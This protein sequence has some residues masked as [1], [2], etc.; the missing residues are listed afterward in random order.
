MQ[1]L[2]SVGAVDAAETASLASAARILGRFLSGSLR[3]VFTGMPPAKRLEEL[4]IWNLACQL[5]DDIGEQISR[6]A[7]GRDWDFRD[8]IVRSSRSTTANIAEGFGHFRPRPFA[9]HLRIAHA[10]AME[11]LSHSRE[12]GVK[13]YF[14]P[15]E[16]TRFRRLSGRILRGV[17]RLIVYL[18]SCDP[19][20][21]LRPASR[22]SPPPARKKLP[23]RSKPAR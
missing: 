6:G 18:D 3:A 21:D 4:I 2:R 13:K 11:T 20:L 5:R 10:S 22:T 8:Q 14:S 23:K 9:N 7:G 15:E 12:G 19:N 16:V 17:A 1:Q